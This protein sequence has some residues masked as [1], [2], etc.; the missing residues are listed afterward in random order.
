MHLICGTVISQQVVDHLI[1]VPS[2][3]LYISIHHACT[4]LICFMED[5]DST[6]LFQQIRKA[7]LQHRSQTQCDT[8]NTQI[9]INLLA[10][11]LGVHLFTPHKYLTFSA[12][13]NHLLSSSAFL[14]RLSAATASW[15][16]S[17]LSELFRAGTGKLQRQASD[18]TAEH[19]A[20]ASPS[21]IS[22]VGNLSISWTLHHSRYEAHAIP[23]P[24]HCP[25]A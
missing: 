1:Y 7:D 14:L 19:T 6:N 2:C 25:S 4:G 3:S 8:A 17:R 10:E 16:P 18:A 22:C 5:E 15:G 11:N 12:S 23:L 21:K 13:W 9:Q 24:E 20:A